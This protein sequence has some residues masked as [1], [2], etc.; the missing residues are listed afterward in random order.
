MKARLR[1][2]ARGLR[3]RLSN[4]AWVLGGGSAA[5]L[6]VGG[7]VRQMLPLR[8]LPTWLAAATTTGIVAAVLTTVAGFGIALYNLRSLD[9]TA[10]AEASG[11]RIQRAQKT[12]E[13]P[14][15]ALGGVL[16]HLDRVWLTRRDGN[17]LELAF[18]SPEEA[19]RFEAAFHRYGG[20]G[21][22]ELQPRAGMT[23]APLVLI[24]M[25]TSCFTLSMIGMV[26]EPRL[27]VPLMIISA[28]LVAGMRLAGA[29]RGKHF[30]L[31]RDGI[32]LGRKF[33][34]FGAIES[35]GFE[36]HRVSIIHKNGEMTRARVN[37]PKELAAALNAELSQRLESDESDESDGGTLTRE[38]GEGLHTWL[39]RIQRAVHD[40]SFRNPAMQKERVRVAAL[41][42]RSPLRVRVAALAS[43][44]DADPE[45]AQELLEVSADPRLEKAA[46]AA[47]GSEE[48]WRRAVERLERQG[49]LE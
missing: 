24:A 16:R 46:K 45:F 31:G 6:V 36:E 15:E 48:D 19:I 18:G 11:V 8:N 30:V 23:T 9:V 40:T 26:E 21:R 34:A 32:R 5:A 29:L 41:H 1:H 47:Q 38:E 44:M 37:M 35:V 13:Y 7:L 3:R 14:Y 22:I 10:S 2:F 39:E 43:L 27:Y 17:V 49:A 33:V 42:P 25:V 28:A 20:E 12:Q 4:L